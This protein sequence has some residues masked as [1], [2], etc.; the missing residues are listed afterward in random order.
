MLVIPAQSASA[1]DGADDGAASQIADNLNEI[2]DDSG[3]ETSPIEIDNSDN[4]TPAQPSAPAGTEGEGFGTGESGLDPPALNAELIAPFAINDG[5]NVKVT[6]IR[7]EHLTSDDQITINDR[8]FVAGTWDAST[9]NPQPGDNFEIQFPT[10]LSLPPVGFTFPLTGADGTDWGTCVVAADNTLSCTLSDAVIDRPEDVHGEWNLWTTAVQSTNAEQLNFSVNGKVVVVD[11]P[12]EGGISDGFEM[13]DTQKT[14]SL[15]N[16]QQSV[17]WTIQ[18]PGSVLSQLSTDGSTVTLDDRLS[19]NMELHNPPAP[20]LESGRGDWS[21]VEGGSVTINQDNVEGEGDDAY[22]PL[23]LKID[24]GEGFNAN[25][26]YRIIYVTKATAGY[27]QGAKFSNYVDINGIEYGQGVGTT[28]SPRTEPYKGGTLEQTDRYGSLRWYVAVPGNWLT[29]NNAASLTL[30]DTFTGG[31][32]V[33]SEKDLKLLIQERD[34]LPALDQTNTPW[35]NVTDQF[36]I[37]LEVAEGGTGFDMTATPKESFDFQASKIYE[38]VYYTQ[39]DKDDIPVAGEDTFTNNAVVNGATVSADVNG[40]S[41]KPSKKGEINYK[42]I[43][44][45]GEEFPWGT[46][47]GWHVETPGQLMEGSEAPFRITDTYSDTQEV[48]APAGADLKDALNLKVTARDYVTGNQANES[49]DVTAGTK[50]SHDPETNQITFEL[51]QIDGKYSR[52]WV[53]VIDYTLCTASGGVDVRG[54]SYSNEIEGLGEK[55]GSKATFNYGGGGTGT[56]VSRG[57]FALQKNLAWDSVRIDPNAHDFTV[58]VEEFA[59]GTNLATDSPNNTYNITVK[60]DG[61]PVNGQFSRGLGWKIRLTEIDL[62][63]VEGVYFEPGQFKAAPGVEVS[64]DGTTAVVEITEPRENVQVQLENKASH[65][66]ASITKVV[67]GEAAGAAAGVN[68]TI[69]AKIDR[70]GNGQDETKTHTIKAGETWNLVDLP[71]GTEITYSEIQPADTDAITWG[72]PQFSPSNTVTVGRDPQTNSVTLTN[73]ADITQGTFSLKKK[74]EGPEQYNDNVPESFT[75]VATWK[76]ANGVEQSKNLVLPAD[77][78]VVDFG[79]ALPSGTKVTLS[80][81]VPENGNGLAWAAPVFS[82]NGVT[83][84]EEDN[85]VVTVGLNPVEVTVKNYVDTN[86]GTFRLLK[87]I[88][89]EAAEGVDKDTEFTVTARWQSGTEFESR[90]LTLRAGEAVNL[91]EMLPVGTQ[92]TFTEGPRPEVA[93]VEWGAI[94]WGTNG[95]NWLHTNSDGSVTGIVSDDPAEGRLITLGNEATW[96][97]GSIGFEK[98]IELDGET[99]PADEFGLPEGTEFQIQIDTIT[100]PAGKTLPE[101]AGI[102]EGDVIVLNAENNFRWESEKILPKDTI[103]TFHEIAPE[104]VPG[105][106]WGLP[107]YENTITVDADGNHVIDVTNRA[108]PTTEVDIDK[109]VTGF[110]GGEV[111]RDTEVL[112]QVTASWNDIDGFERSCILNVV[113]GQPAQP[114]AECDATVI[115]GKVYLPLNTEI[116]LKETGAYTSVDNV[117]WKDIIWSVDEGRAKVKPVEGDETATVATINGDGSESVTFGLENKISSNGLIIIPLPIPDLP[118]F[119][120]SSTPPGPDTPGTPGDPGTPGEPGEPGEPGKPGEPGTPGEPGEPG[121]PGKPGQPSDGTPG[122]PG[123][124]ETGQPAM[125]DGSDGTAAAQQGGSALA[126]TGANVLWLVGGA[127]VLILGGA[128]LALRGRRN[129]A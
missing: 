67:N 110:K 25:E 8:V 116:T 115:N 66:S 45:A 106:N 60:A 63:N 72:E 117:N 118:D 112:F 54:T 75:V 46:T 30:T 20:R 95:E 68:F 88:S 18:V 57:S 123:K 125:V 96:Q 81:I 124:P 83:F 87:Q 89:G 14:G 51:P 109:E 15:R 62:P 49:V 50:V 90:L 47:I 33:D 80:E 77:G 17:E 122:I 108:E 41:F 34:Y 11:L 13:G 37:D 39:V 2:A 52:D 27:V 94:T 23:T 76:D 119:P 126:V 114:T 111:E 40:R 10:E 53:Y 113:P 97:P 65:S 93:G 59:P 21:A 82:G 98:L 105:Y 31:H 127:L 44:I 1:Q 71:I 9:A 101:G 6:E 100:F 78:S 79:E 58:K 26:M 35:R 91:G 85:A 84:D 103:V 56:G 128:W 120:G 107:R 48:C 19:A 28:F 5:I 3:V 12:G 16:D 70:P 104:P 69:N 4:E 129:E 55:F 102:A 73:T 74:L 7:S 43:T 99:T 36:T 22:R 38:I 42:P 86:D 92:V 32:S 61:T 24:S 29:A 121:K 64:E